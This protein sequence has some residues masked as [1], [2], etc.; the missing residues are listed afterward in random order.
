MNNRRR[1]GDSMIEL[2]LLIMILTTLFTGVWRFGWAFYVYNHLQQ[3]VRAAGR[4]ASLRT[5]DSPNSTPSSEYATAVQNVAVYGEP[6]PAAD[7]RPLVP[8]LAPGHVAVSATF[9]AGVPRFITVAI[10]N[11]Q[12][13]AMLETVTLQNKPWTTFPYVGTF[14]PP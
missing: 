8:G 14:G 12:I 11:Y 10:N 7:A 1:R 3:G 6:H 5:Y 13:P 4:Y 2:T 9:A